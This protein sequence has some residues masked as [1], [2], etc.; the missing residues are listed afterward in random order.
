M[1]LLQQW[2][3]DQNVWMQDSYQIDIWYVAF[4]GA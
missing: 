2:V 1:P 3:V 4:V